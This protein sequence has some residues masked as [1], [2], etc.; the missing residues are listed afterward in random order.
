M[1]GV[2]QTNRSGLWVPAIPLPLYGINSV[3]CG[4]CEQTFRGKKQLREL[5]YRE[6][7]ALAH[8]LDLD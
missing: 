1:N 2:Q 7:Y 8:I 4:A 5:R 3:R 6:H